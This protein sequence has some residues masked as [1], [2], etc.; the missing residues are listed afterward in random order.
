M[1]KVD[2]IE[3][4]RD[5][6]QGIK[7]FIPTARKV[8]YIQMLLNCN[9]HTLDLG[10][11]V[12]PKA[13]PQMQ[14]TK[15]V[16]RQLDFSRSNS[17]ILTVVVNERG[18][19]EAVQFEQ[20][21]CLGYPFSISETFQMRNTHKTIQES[22]TVL[23]SIYAISAAAKKEL[24]VYLSM[25]FGNPYG[26]EWNLDLVNYW[27]SELV[28]IGVKVIS[29]SDTVGS[30]NA[31]IIESVYRFLIPKFPEITFG[32]HLHTTKSSW[33]E[34]LNAAYMS[35]CR[36]FDGAIQGF[37]GCPMA[38]DAL[39]G[40]MPTEQMLSYFAQQKAVHSIETLA[41]ESAHNRATMLFGEYV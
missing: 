29:L 31:S 24:V 40:N 15:E 3:C 12:S 4:P 33:F 28:N 18:A 7:S 9:F 32:A 41:F 8:E 37:G 6:M 13:I 34:K 26:E 16:I 5:A 22:L 39:V 1:E 2:L 38:G 11:F 14:D 36:R 17:K 19:Q 25:G 23:R 20:I 30:S 35:G 27:V 10:S 21:D